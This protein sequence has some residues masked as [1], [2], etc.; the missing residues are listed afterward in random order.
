MNSSTLKSL[1]SQIG[2]LSRDEQLW[3]LERLARLLRET[4][5]GDQAAIEGDL[6]AMASDPEI[7]RELRNIDEEFAPTER[8][9]LETP[10]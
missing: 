10:Q 3:L 7:Q 5:S 2:E 1:D 4:A 8:D 6:A 9:G